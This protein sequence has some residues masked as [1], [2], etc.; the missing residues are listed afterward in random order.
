M[1]RWIA[2]LGNDDPDVRETALQ[3]LMS[4]SRDDLPAL[5]DA[6]KAQPGLM[7][8]QVASLREVVTQVFLAS[9]EYVATAQSIFGIALAAHSPRAERSR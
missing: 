7:P 2:D 4:L 6:A 1:S 8:A 3:D 9:E 5:R